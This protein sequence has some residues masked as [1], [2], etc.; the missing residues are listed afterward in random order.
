VIVENAKPYIIVS[1]F[2]DFGAR[3]VLPNL[4]NVCRNPVLA[5]QKALLSLDRGEPQVL[6]PVKK[7]LE[8]NGVVSVTYAP[9]AAA[10]SMIV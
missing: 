5:G 10:L 1:L 4:A 2:E 9:H 7:V 6:D 3:I 8:Q